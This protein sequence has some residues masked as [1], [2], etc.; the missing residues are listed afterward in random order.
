MREILKIMRFDF[1]TARPLAII[2]AVTV[3]LIFFGLSL[4]F[5]PLICS[6]ITFGAMVF[7]IPLQAV[8]D[9]SGF[10]KLYGTLPVRR[11]N[12]TRA[13]FLYIFLVHFAVE[14]LELLLAVTAMSLKLYRVLPNQNSEMMQMVKESFEDTRLTLLMIIGAFTVFCLIFSY[15]EMMGQIYGRENEF[16]IIMITL[17][18]LTGLLIVFL[19]LSDHEIIPKIHMPSLPGTVQ[20][21][22]LLGAALNIVM[23]GICLIFGEITAHK[24]AKREL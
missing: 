11:S 7:V 9:K 20:G 10:H 18:V 12:I 19:T 6:Y 14:I 16:K 8:A 15:M 13:R 3:A 21:L 24:L 2:P 23:C 5:A 4:F 1:L 17:G 22:L